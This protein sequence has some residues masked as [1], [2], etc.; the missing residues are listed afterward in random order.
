MKTPVLK[1]QPSLPLWGRLGRKWLLGLAL[2]LGILLWPTHE[3]VSTV[4]VVVPKKMGLLTASHAGT[5]EEWCVQRG[6]WVKIGQPVARMAS[7]WVDARLKAAETQGSI[8]QMQLYRIEHEGASSG[9]IEQAQ[10][11]FQA[12]LAEVEEAR[13]MASELVLRSPAE[14]HVFTPRWQEMI[15]VFLTEGMPVAQVVDPKSYVLQ[16]PLSED[17]AALVVL[18]ARVEGQ[19]VGSAETF[20]SFITQVP[21]KKIGFNDYKHGFYANFGGPVPMQNLQGLDPLQAEQALYPIFLAEA[22]MAAPTVGLQEQMR[23]RVIIYGNRTILALKM[24]KML[25]RI[26]L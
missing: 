3:T 20:E 14:G 5:L 24:F 8:A 16:I 7:P 22:A 2:S 19:W 18:N 17:E 11:Q 26:L 12:A 25:K 15:G 13:L 1:A 6:E 21:E 4:G 23:A 9:L 10:F